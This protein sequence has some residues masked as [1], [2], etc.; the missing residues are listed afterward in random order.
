MILIVKYMEGSMTTKSCLPASIVWLLKLA[1]SSQPTYIYRQ[2]DPNLELGTNNSA[3]FTFKF[4][5]YLNLLSC[6]H[7]TL[8]TVS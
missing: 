5:A 4:I 7:P 6:P 1:I 3:L 2:Q 8:T